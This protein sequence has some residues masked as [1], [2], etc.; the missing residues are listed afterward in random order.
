MGLPTAD[1]L[2]HI[3]PDADEATPPAFHPDAQGQLQ[4]K[5]VLT[6]PGNDAQKDAL[7]LCLLALPHAAAQHQRFKSPPRSQIHGAV[8]GRLVCTHWLR[9]QQRA[10]STDHSRAAPQPLLC[11]MP[12]AQRTASR[13]TGPA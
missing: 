4:V 11:S 3:F 7:S 13:R 2:C 9:H 1:T 8:L 12:Q 5:L 6:W 10:D